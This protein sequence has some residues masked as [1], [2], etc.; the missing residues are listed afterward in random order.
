MLIKLKPKL[1]ISSLFALNAIILF[2]ILLL[3]NLTFIMSYIT[4]KSERNITEINNQLEQ[5]IELTDSKIVMNPKGKK[6]LLQEGIWVQIIDNSLNEVYSFNK[7]Q[8]IPAS[9]TPIQLVHSY[10]F[11][12]GENTIFVFEK[13]F[14]HHSFSYLI[15]IPNI[16]VSRYIMTYSSSKVERLFGGSY[17]FVILANIIVILLFS[18]LIFAKKIG[19]PLQEMIDRI[20]RISR[21]DSLNPVHAKGIYSDVFKSLDNLTHQLNEAKH[22]KKLLDNMREQWIENLSHDLKTPLSSIRGFSEIMKSHKYTFN[23]NEVKEYSSIIY[24]KACYLEELITDLNYAQKL[25]SAAIPVELTKTCIYSFIQS[26]VKEV[27]NNPNFMDRNINVKRFANS[28]IIKIDPKLMKRA[29]EN[30]ITNFLLYNTPQET[31]VIEI[32]EEEEN[33]KIKISD[34]GSGIP[35]DQLPYVFERYYRGTNTKANKNG[36]GL[37]M[38]IAKEIVLLHNGKCSIDSSEIKGTTL[39]IFIPKQSLNH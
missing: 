12:V 34:N 8:E 35:Q 16:E 33:V 31:I 22:E 4:S 17:I 6:L 32:H 5:T 23:G 2:I 24:N 37:G 1:K 14:K 9:Y 10:K 36:S 20:K 11:S 27:L 28:P 30:I 18:Y 39:V 25:R 29:L 13:S 26:L 21:N 15:G 38:A 19:K 3:I 7:P